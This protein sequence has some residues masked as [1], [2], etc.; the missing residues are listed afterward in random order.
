MLVNVMINHFSKLSIKIEYFVNINKKIIY[1]NLLKMNGLSFYEIFEESLEHP[2]ILDEF[3][4]VIS[5]LHKKHKEYVF[6]DFDAYQE[7]VTERWKNPRYKRMFNFFDDLNLLDRFF[8]IDNNQGVRIKEF[9]TPNHLNLQNMIGKT[10]D[11]KFE[12]HPRQFTKHFLCM[13]RKERIHRKLMYDFLSTELLDKT[14]LSYTPNDYKNP[15]R[16]IIDDLSITEEGKI[17]SAWTHPLQKKSFCNIV[18]ET[19]AANGT[20]HITEKTDKCF[21]AGQPFILV[22]GPLYLKKLKE[23]GFKTFDKWWDESYDEEWDFDKR[24]EKIKNTIREVSSWSIKECEVKYL[25]MIDILNHNQQLSRK[26]WE[27]G[28][29]PHNFTYLEK[30]IPKKLAI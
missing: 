2:K 1:L 22:A 16:T 24:I 20:I 17:D 13:N 5:Y 18:T 19:T 15:R 14:Y 8:L 6:W 23:Y 7:L 26:F 30:K 3:K 12:I 25:E 10:W 9:D 29:F 11:F 28:N 4:E 27:N 21:T